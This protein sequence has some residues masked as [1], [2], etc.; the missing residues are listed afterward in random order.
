MRKLTF[1][2]SVRI[3]SKVAII[4]LRDVFFVVWALARTRCCVTRAE[5]L[6][7]GLW[8]TIL[9][10][11]KLTTSERDGYF[12]LRQSLTGLPKITRDGI[13]P[14]PQSVGLRGPV[15]FDSWQEMKHS[16]NVLVFLVLSALL[17][18]NQASFLG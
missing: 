8:L 6:C 18:L 5:S 12:G 4:A 16:G 14:F 1:E 9:N 10:L 15:R 2:S 3:S 17:V 13:F 7:Y 11:Q